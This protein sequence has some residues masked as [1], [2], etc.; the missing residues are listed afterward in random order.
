MHDIMHNIDSKQQT[1][2]VILDFIKAF[3]TVPY[4]K[5]NKYGIN[6][7]TEKWIQSFLKHRKQQVV[8]EGESSMP[9]SVDSGV[10]QATVVGPLLSLCHTSNLPLRVTSKVRLFADDCLLYG[11][12][13]IPQMI[14]YYSGKS[15]Q[16]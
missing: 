14:N 8:V 16:P 1:D 6:G 5:L 9:C 13:Y 2:L 10:H 7:N 15:L 12:I 11:P 3:D 4:K